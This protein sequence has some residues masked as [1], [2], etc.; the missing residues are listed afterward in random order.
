MTASVSSVL[1]LIHAQVEKGP[2]S[3]AVMARD[4]Q[5][6]YRE[7]DERSDD[8]AALLRSVG[9]RAEVR[10]GLCLRR[11][12]AL[13]VAEL[14]VW[15]AGGA[16]V[17]LDPNDPQTR[18]RMLLENAQSKIAITDSTA[19][20]S[21]PTGTW[22]TIVLDENGSLQPQDQLVPS[23][24]ASRPK[25]Q[26]PAIKPDDAA[27]V[28][29]TSGSTGQPKGVEIT[30][31]NLLH[32]LSWHTRAFHVSASDKATMISSPGFDASIWELWPYLCAGSEVHVVDDAI[33]TAP[34]PLRDWM[35]EAGITISFLPTAL[36]ES[37]IALPWPPDISLRYLLTGAD[38][39]RRYPPPGLP[40]A[41]V[42]NYGP[43]EC[44]VV[45]TSGIVPQQNKA[46]ALPAIGKAID[47]VQIYVVDEQLKPVPQGTSGELLV[48]GAGIG[49]GY[50]NLPEAT[51]SKFLPNHLSPGS[52]RLYRTGDLVRL[53]PD[54]QVAFLG[55]IDQQIKVRGYRVEPGEISAALD[56]HPAIESS[57]V[58]ARQDGS[59]E[60]R[61]VA[62]VVLKQNSNVG[63]DEVRKLVS[64]HLPEYM[65]PGTFV[66]IA[67]LPITSHGKVDR[68]AL[69]EPTP[70][71]MLANGSFEP[72]QSEVERWLAALLSKLLGVPQVSR[73]DNFFRLGGHSLLGAQLI[74][75]I[76]RNFGVELSLRSLFDHPTVS[77]IASEIGGL[78]D[79]QLNAMSELEAQQVLD[80]LSGPGSV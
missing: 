34:E 49:R 6:S 32:L 53:L 66:R 60:P 26:A 20:R 73:N 63:A 75:E 42:N 18:L 46:D 55:R 52:G 23:H 65:V 19:Q 45:A 5:L 10:V 67:R 74:G 38:V 30:H 7:L 4:C 48:G 79:S 13:V 57:V 76:H 41:L 50:L 3:L 47:D 12:P 8:L 11:S 44:T 9:V 24:S 21:V 59:Q 61:L 58:I 80:S 71:N 33:R 29:F 16:F 78:I 64:D 37:M 77:G 62:Y 39:L 14:A 28:I 36:A 17:P 72:A 27:Y 1:S 15:K 25:D 2:Q 31:G 69:P 51:A 68:D 43:T 54:G 56:R 40:F 22:Q 35:I 70:E